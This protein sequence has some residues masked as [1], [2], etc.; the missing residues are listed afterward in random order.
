MN[1]SGL[2]CTRNC[3]DQDY[4]FVECITSMLTYCD[5]VVVHDKQSTDGT[6]EA[7]KEWASRDPRIRVIEGVWENPRGDHG[8]Y[9]RW[10]NEA[11]SHVRHGMLLHMDADEVISE[12]YATRSAIQACVEKKDAIA[13]D[14][15][16]FVRDARSVIP[17]GECCGR[18]VVRV[19]PS[20]LHWVS[21]EP[22]RRG[23]VPLLDIAHIEP[24]ARIYHL[25]FLRRRE[26]F[27]KKA[28]VV[29]GAFFNEF[30]TRLATAE[31]EGG[32]PFEKFPWWNRL[33]R[34]TGDYPPSVRSWLLA[35]GYSLD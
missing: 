26:A 28:R 19:G 21:D 34:Y 25:G 6:L 9:V 10:I 20:H 1:L 8:W 24:M 5:E 18:W 2:V 4:C 22:H 13:L 29:L 11:K 32:H 35:R 31:S 15:I 14:R 12:D 30:D 33:D 17:E 3:I 16:N 27:Y 23:E 7:L